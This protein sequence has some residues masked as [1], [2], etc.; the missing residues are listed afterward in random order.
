MGVMMMEISM[1]G[2][3]MALVM[4]DRVTG[5]KAVRVVPGARAELSAS[6]S[7]EI[8]KIIAD[9]A[10]EISR[11]SGDDLALCPVFVMGRDGK[12][13]ECVMALLPVGEG[14]GCLNWHRITLE[15]KPARRLSDEERMDLLI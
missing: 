9:M 4:A 11:G 6:D 3:D 2:D 13:S 14:Y 5:R 7:E 8:K 12:A 15:E 1:T 10:A